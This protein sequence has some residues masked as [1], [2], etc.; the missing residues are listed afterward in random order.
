MKKSPPVPDSAAAP[1]LPVRSLG[2]TID[3][4]LSP[5]QQRFNRLLAR[6]D[7]L[8][9]QLDALHSLAD[10]QRPLHNRTLQPLRERRRAAMRKMALWLD[11]RL[12]GQGLSKAHKQTATD[13]LCKLCE[14][15][16][17][18]GDQ[19]MRALHDQYSPFSL[20]EMQQIAAARVRAAMEDQLGRPLDTDLP[21][22]TLDEVLFAGMR[23]LREEAEAAE[24]AQAQVKRKPSASQRRADQ[25]QEDAD[26]TLRKL[27][28]QLSSALHPDRELDPAARNEKHVLM[29]E[30]NTAYQ[31]RDL[32][33]LL[34]IQLRLAQADPQS[35]SRMAE[36][37]IES[38]SL[39]LKQQTAELERELDSQKQQMGHEFG[40]P[41]Y[42]PVS[43]ASLR[44]HLAMEKQALN[45]DVAAMEQDLRTVRDDASFKRWLKQ[46]K[47]MAERYDDF[48]ADETW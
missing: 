23:Q 16:A 42:A 34:H 12:Q 40:L 17:A 33:A 32:V 37:K 36:D 2:G 38:M 29:V 46:Q 21:L 3:Q 4:P 41:D 47:Q 39:L 22:D 8:Q 28:R 5:G 43:A 13:I 35:L 18:D 14:T 7:K 30:A 48:D 1:S 25:Q 45:Q 15:L 10:S 6:I 19:A 20:A 44:S 11:E 26:T 9:Q 24:H 31:R 27:Y